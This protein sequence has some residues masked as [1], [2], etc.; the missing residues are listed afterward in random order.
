MEMNSAPSFNRTT[1]PKFNNLQILL[2][3]F[4]ISDFTSLEKFIL[5]TRNGN[6]TFNLNEL[7]IVL[8]SFYLSYTIF[9]CTLMAFLF[10]VR[11]GKTRKCFR[12]GFL[13]IFIGNVV[14]GTELQVNFEIMN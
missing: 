12:C 13:K 11:A 3:F 10:I 5:R 2:N 6:C 7:I 14:H 4:F 8:S 9:Y 1:N